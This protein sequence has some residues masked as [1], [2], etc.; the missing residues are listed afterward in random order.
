MGY[1]NEMRFSIVAPKDFY[2]SEGYEFRLY[3]ETK[4]KYA[5]YTP[6][7][8]L[9]GALPLLPEEQDQLALLKTPIEKYMEEFTVRFITGDVDLSKWDEY[10]SGYD[11]LKV[12]DF[13]ALLQKGFDGLKK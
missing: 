1:T 6:K 4:D 7:E 12:N 3:T 9:P 5:P 2:S 10:V 8:V 11:K 13:V